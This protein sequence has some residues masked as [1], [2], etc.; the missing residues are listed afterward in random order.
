[1]RRHNRTDDGES[2]VR[3]G[4][5]TIDLG[6]RIVMLNERRV[7]LTPKEYRLLQMLA[8]NAGKVVTHQQLIHGVWG[9][10][11]TTNPQYLRIFM[12]KLRRKIEAVPN[13]PRIILTE[14]GVGY[15]LAQATFPATPAAN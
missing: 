1:M 12:R 3:A 8:Q 2:V 15:R 10:N 6:S 13:R 4:P 14:L 7:A 5:L 11:E 9:A